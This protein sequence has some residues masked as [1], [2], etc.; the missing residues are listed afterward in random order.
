MKN[1]RFRRQTFF[2]FNVFIAF[3]PL[4]SPSVVFRSP[5]YRLLWPFFPFIIQIKKKKTARATYVH[6]ADACFYESN[7]CFVRFFF[8]S[9]SVGNNPMN[10]CT[11]CLLCNLIHCKIVKQ[12]HMTEL[13]LQRNVTPFVWWHS[14]DEWKNEEVNNKTWDEKKEMWNVWTIAK[15]AYWTSY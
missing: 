14:Y 11:W 7:L 15:N 6:Q 5:L 4:P 12:W 9:S 8:F 1:I 10:E 3:Q 13:R 2:L